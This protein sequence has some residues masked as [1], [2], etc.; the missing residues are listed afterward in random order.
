M[1]TTET[2]VADLQAQRIEKL[3]NT[4][5]ELLLCARGNDHVLSKIHGALDEDRR[6]GI[7][8][9]RAREVEEVEN[10][11]LER[12]DAVDQGGEQRAD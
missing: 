12:E 10:G 3:S 1:T 9:H 5:H 4:L 7:A 11:E 6:L 2:T 8:T